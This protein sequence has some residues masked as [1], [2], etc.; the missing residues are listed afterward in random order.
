MKRLFGSKKKEVV[1]PPVP[2]EPF[3]LE[4]HQNKLEN[5]NDTVSKQLQE[6]E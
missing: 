3:N 1:P 5:Q 4:K 2:A 6:I